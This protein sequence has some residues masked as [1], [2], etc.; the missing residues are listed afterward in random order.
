MKP[1]KPG[2]Q[3]DPTGRHELRYSDGA[4][5]T[6]HVSDQGKTSIDPPEAGPV[7]H[8]KIPGWWVLGGGAALALGSF[9]PWAQVGPFSKNGIDG[10]GTITLALAALIIAVAWPVLKTSVGMARSVI[11]AVAAMLAMGVCV[12]DI[13]D[14]S[15]SSNDLVHVSVGIGL[16]MAAAGAVA[17]IVGSVLGQQRHVLFTS[18][19]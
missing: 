4:R 3:P 14:V 12:Y 17:V 2:W 8:D 9:L 15:S 6:E 19:S 18:P 1:L 10:D 11:T 5:W 13:A 16:W 7:Q